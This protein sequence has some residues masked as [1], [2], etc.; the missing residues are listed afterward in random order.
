MQSSYFLT[1]LEHVMASRAEAKRARETPRFLR[2]RAMA[3]ALTG[4]LIC[5][6]LLKALAIAQGDLLA[7]GGD[8]SNWLFGADP[9]S[10]SIAQA[11]GAS[12]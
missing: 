8:R 1:R 6:I 7:A 12:I 10:Q 5:L 3:V 2:L 4:A 9:V 11:F